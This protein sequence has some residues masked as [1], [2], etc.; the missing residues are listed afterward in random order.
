MREN[1]LKICS[2]ASD[3]EEVTGGKMRNS[4]SRL[5]AA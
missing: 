5:H 4:G 1:D 3:Q 2:E